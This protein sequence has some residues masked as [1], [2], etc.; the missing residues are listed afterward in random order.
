MR[1]FT[2]AL[3]L[4]WSVASA[5][6]ALLIENVTLIDGTGR[7]P[8]PGVSVLVDGDKI[9]LVRDH[10]LKAPMGATVVDGRGKFLIP[11]LIDTH[12]HLEGGRKGAMGGQRVLTVDKDTGRRMLHGYLYS[13]VTAVY[14]CGNNPDF[15]LAMRDDERSGR[16][17]SP[18]IFATGHLITRTAGYAASGG[19]AAID[20]YEQGI[21]SL[22][23]LFPKK[24]DLVKFV[25][26]TRNVGGSDVPLPALDEDVLRRLIRYTNEHGFPT[27]IHA[28]DAGAQRAAVYAGIDALAHPVY[29]TETD[30][31]LAPLIAAKGLVVVSSL[32]V[33]QNIVSVARDPS[34][35]DQPLFKAVMAPEDLAFFRD[36][37]HKRYRAIAMDKW[38]EAALRMGSTNVRK[39]YDAGATIAMG[40]DRT[41]G[42]YVH[43]EL[44]LLAGLGIPPIE[45][46]RMATLNA[47]KYIRKDRTLGSIEEGKIADLVLLDA[48]P[49][50][51]IRN[52]KRIRAVIVGGRMIDRDTLDL[53]VNR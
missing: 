20:T 23:A 42:P 3:M 45:V 33:L 8:Q 50:A 25:L 17:I 4:V 9:A 52:S 22:D 30:D 24:P 51:D 18:R 36:A 41:F 35:F 40:T 27:T 32:V 14:D 37:E 16:M 13:G 5:Q 26:A 7:P 28:V 1:T 31:T 49:T 2:A 47:A 46:I 29:M 43:W 38:G 44:E 12:I 10:A 11:G 34:F 53:P 15:I 39:L 48:D 6:A 21:K 19:G